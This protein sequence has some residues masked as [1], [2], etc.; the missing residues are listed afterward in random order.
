MIGSWVFAQCKNLKEADLSG[1][2]DRQINSH[3][4]FECT[5]LAK[6]GLPKKQIRVFD[7][8]CFYHTALEEIV[9]DAKE[10]T[11]RQH[12]FGLANLKKVVIGETCDNIQMHDYA[13]HQAE[14]KEFIVP[15]FLSKCFNGILSRI[16]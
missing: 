8:S 15:D 7:S 11:V 3:L 2:T 12:A 6:V 5:S 10:V 4:F 14:V 1:I 13:F 9:F 16:M